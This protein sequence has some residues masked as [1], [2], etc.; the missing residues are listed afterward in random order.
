MLLPS[1]CSGLA[2]NYSH[3]ESFSQILAQQ[4]WDNF[5]DELHV[6]KQFLSRECSLQQIQNLYNRWMEY[7]T[8]KPQKDASWH[9]VELII[10]ENLF[11][12]RSTTLRF[13]GGLHQLLVGWS[14]LAEFQPEW[15]DKYPADQALETFILVWSS[16]YSLDSK[17][18]IIN[19][20]DFCVQ[21]SWFF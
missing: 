2:V 12:S 11:P 18:L 13:E 17:N 4:F 7:E 1:P 10:E 8:N 19:I 5:R 16:K 21:C 9:Q 15:L 14:E 6:Y 3:G 20:H